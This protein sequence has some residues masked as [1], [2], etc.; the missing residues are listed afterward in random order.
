[1]SKFCNPHGH[2]IAKTLVSENIRKAK[3][4]FGFE[5]PRKKID[6][7]SAEGLD[8]LHKLHCAGYSHSVMAALMGTKRKTIQNFL[9][10]LR[11]DARGER[12]HDN[13]DVFN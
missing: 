3:E 12:K 13:S 2:R 8:R 1:M 7:L 11:K 5:V 9:G 4:Q 6:F 10:S